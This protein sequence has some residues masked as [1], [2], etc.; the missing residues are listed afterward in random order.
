MNPH[1]TMW[2]YL[3][4]L[5][6]DGID[7]V[8]REMKETIGLTALS[9]ATHYH[10]VEH[11]R[12][13][14][15]GAFIYRAPSS[16]YFEPDESYWKDCPIQH[17]VA[18]IAK[19][20][21]L[22]RV[23]DRAQALDLELVSWTICCHSTGLGQMYPETT[24]QN[25]LGDRYPEALCPANP[26][27]RAFLRALLADLSHNYPISLMELESC[28]YQGARHYHGHE[29][30]PIPPGPLDLFLLALCFCEHC[31]ARARARGVDAKM[32]RDHVAAALRRSL[33][34][35]EPA[36]GTIEAFIDQTPGLKDFVEVRVEVVSSLIEELTQ[37][38]AAPL[39]PIVWDTREMVGSDGRKLTRIAGSMTI[40]AY[41]ADVQQIR[42]HIQEAITLAGDV[43][44]LRVGYHT[45]PPTTPDRQTLLRNIEASLDLGVRAF[46]FY[47]YG[48]APRPSLQWTADAVRLIRERTA[49]DIGPES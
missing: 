17:Q 24:Q 49:S 42:C 15:R 48:I 41:A 33:D 2:C 39:S 35:G 8:L 32:V 47:N 21:P 5:L 13:H 31:M 3:W 26:A 36:P 38:S 19:G 44:K 7:E 9:L 46:S 14:T 20:N 16:L 22:A 4:N 18:S 34:A 40:A 27:V 29:K 11:L 37:A 1:I 10:S 12:P 25:A 23:A 45:Y 30:I 28:H 43:T 6:D